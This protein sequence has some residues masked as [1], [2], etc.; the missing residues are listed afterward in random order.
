MNLIRSQV[1]NDCEIESRVCNYDGHSVNAIG[2]DGRSFNLDCM[3]SSHEFDSTNLNIQITNFHFRMPHFPIMPN[4]CSSCNIYSSDFLFNV[5][6]DA[7]QEDDKLF[8]A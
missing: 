4:F 8:C 3:A 5:H 6:E 1:K 7:L 2:R